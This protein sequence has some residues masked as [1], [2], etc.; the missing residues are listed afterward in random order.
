MIDLTAESGRLAALGR[1]AGKVADAGVNISIAY[2]ATRDRVALV[3][4][5][6]DKAREALQA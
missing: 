6:N 4:S 1:V 2:L 5:D 3:T